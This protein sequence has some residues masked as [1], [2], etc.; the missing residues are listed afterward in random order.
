MAKERLCCC[1]GCQRFS[2]V[3]YIQ[4]IKSFLQSITF[5]NRKSAFYCNVW[6][7]L[8]FAVFSSARFIYN[9]PSRYPPQCRHVQSDNRPKNSRVHSLLAL[10]WPK[11][12]GRII[13]KQCKQ[14]V[15]DEIGRGLYI[16]LARRRLHVRKKHTGQ[17]RR[18]NDSKEI[19][20]YMTER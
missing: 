6:E 19:R 20:L 8:S 14:M 15:S 16:F 2:Q 13:V 3:V 17:W 11:L 4:E 18:D 10:V 1:C 9:W 12:I 5:K 7:T